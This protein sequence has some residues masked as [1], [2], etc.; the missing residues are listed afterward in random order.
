[1]KKRFSA[2]YCLDL[3]EPLNSLDLPHVELDH[4]GLASWALSRQKK[5]SELPRDDVYRFVH[6]GNDYEF[7]RWAHDHYPDY[8][9]LSASKKNDIFD[10]WISECKLNDE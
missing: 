4:L 6:W 5:I 9:R 2:K 1:M 10:Q 3:P 8:W 7:H